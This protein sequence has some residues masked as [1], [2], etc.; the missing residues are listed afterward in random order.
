MFRGRLALL[1]LGLGCFTAVLTAR[2]SPEVVA[3]NTAW[4]AN[5][6]GQLAVFDVSNSTNAVLISTQ[7]T[8]NSVSGVAVFGHNLAVAALN[9]GL[10]LYDLSAPPNPEYVGIWDTLGS[11]LDVAVTNGAAFIAEGGSGIEIIDVHDPVN[12]LGLAALGTTGSVSSVQISGNLLYAACG[13]AGLRIFDV[14][15]PSNPVLRGQLATATASLSVRVTGTRAYVACAGQLAIIDVSSAAAP[16]LISTRATTSQVTDLDVAGSLVVL[17]DTNGVLTGLS[18]T[19]PAA[20]VV[21]FTNTVTAPAVAV[22]VVGNQAFVGDGTGALQIVG[23]SGLAPAPPVVLE[24]V[25]LLKQ[26][27]GQAALLSVVAVGSPPLTYQWYAGGNAVT[28]NGR[29][30]GAGTPYLGFTSLAPSDSG[31]YAVAISNAAGWAISS[32]ILSVL[33]PGTPL[34]EGSLSVT[35]MVMGVDSVDDIVFAAAGA[36]GLA[37]Y[38]A[39]DP[40]YPRFLGTAAVAGSALG[41]SVVNDE[42]FVAA[43]SGGLQIYSVANSVQPSL[44][45]GFQTNGTAYGLEVVEGIVYLAAGGGGLQIINATNPT[46]PLFLGSYATGGTVSGVDVAG[47]MAFVA[48]GLAGV[49]VLS[50]T[51]P[52]SVTL[53]GAYPVIGL[54]NNIEVEGNLAYVAAGRAGLLVLNVSNPAN[55]VLAGSYATGGPVLALAV[56][57]GLA[58][59]AEGTNGVEVVNVA[60]PANIVSFGGDTTVTNAVGLKLIGAT[61]YVALANNGIRILNLSGITAPAPQ[62][63]TPPADVAT[64]PQQT[65]S[66]HV[67]A[68]GSAPLTYQWYK[69]GQILFESAT[70]QGAATATLVLLNAQYADSGSY[71]VVVKNGW[72]LTV[73]GAANVSVVP[74][75]TPVFTSAYINANDVLGVQVVGQLAY[76]AN[77]LGGLQVVDCHDPL[78]PALLGSHATTGLAQAVKVSGNLAYVAAW[79]GGLDIFDVFDPANIVLLGQCAISGFAKGVDVTNLQAYVAGYQGGLQVIDV[80]DP[81]HPFLVGQA[82]TDGFA[83][84]V[85]VAGTNAYVACSQAGLEVF[86]V[87]DPLAI[88]RLGSVAMAGN[89]EGL[90]L[91]TNLA[92]VAIDNGGLAVIDISNPAS[93]QLISTQAIGGDAF[94]VQM[95]GN[96]AYVAGGLG[97]VK[98]FDLG[99]PAQPALVLSGIAGSS[100]HGLQLSGNYAFLADRQTGLVVSQLIGLPALPPR[101]LEIP[102]SVAGVTGQVLTISART[103]GTPPLSFQWYWNGAPLVSTGQVS[104]ATGPNLRLQGLSTLLAG[105]YQL[106]VSSPYGSVS[107]NLSLTVSTG[108][109]PLIAPSFQTVPTNQTVSAG[110]T[111]GFNA[112][113]LG[114]APLDCRWYHNGLPLTDGARVTGSGTPNLQISGAQFQDGGG[115]QLKVWNGAGLAATAPVTLTFVG[116]LQSQL[117]AAVAGQVI[118]L[119]AGVYNETLVL[120]KDVTLTGTAGYATVLDPLGLGIG[121]HVL[122]G[123]N[124]HASLGTAAQCAVGGHR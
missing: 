83:T 85:R 80:H 15:D 96:L 113:L 77:R 44:L 109:V 37:S 19:N 114:S 104:G 86:G 76:L 106:Q 66:L 34:A 123:V 101:L 122:P 79:D 112:T 103:D 98:V 4:L 58:V 99:N 90:E 84:G 10:I 69:D 59:L 3:G 102:A 110:G 78:N 36:A 2:G 75:G 87:A 116:A 5:A 54:V 21:L 115:Y 70:V 52:A 6:P 33:T 26:A 120:A 124:H 9:E 63:L 38:D 95:S 105:N 27:A 18:F 56:A 42:A 35:G 72:N 50:V 25:P 31:I 14:T 12:P 49:Q 67:V 88:H 108:G 93:P 32:N 1:V 48:A 47:G 82:A 28:N 29:I 91:G 11:A 13:G 89:A 97:K 121:V 51:N 65:V 71:S 30:S 17:A 22:R 117:N 39:T 8:S 73:T 40:R 94:Q 62:I 23:L 60:N 43:G 64:L 53:L 61:V 7:L 16:F 107:S 55:P 92:Y 81:T 20:P 100:V 46:Q 119:P 118:T 111:A 45:G 74:L 68:S 57:D 41:V 24:P